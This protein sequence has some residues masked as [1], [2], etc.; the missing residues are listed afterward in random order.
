V[1]IRC[2]SVL[3]LALLFVPLA[4]A[5]PL[6]TFQVTLQ[7]GWMTTESCP[8]CNGAFQAD[9]SRAIE[10][11]LRR[12]VRDFEKPQ[13]IPVNSS[14]QAASY[15]KMHGDGIIVAVSPTDYRDRFTRPKLKGPGPLQRRS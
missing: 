13:F 15:L 12:N 11:V 14:G 3:A 9:V 5:Q 6:R 1:Q 7:Y 10:D 4:E 8:D 2:S